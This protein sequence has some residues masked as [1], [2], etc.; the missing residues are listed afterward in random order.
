MIEPND[1]IL[2]G[3]LDG[4][5]VVAIVG[6]S[7]N[8]ARPSYQ[9]AQFWQGWGARIVPVNPGHAGELILGEQVWPDLAAIPAQTAVDTLDIFRRSEAVPDIVD[10]ALV[11]LP[12]LAVIWMQLGIRHPQAAV[13]ARARG[14]LV[15]EDRCPKI[16]AARLWFPGQPPTNYEV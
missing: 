3:A 11:H 2:R 6:L 9:V 1:N 5:H 13:R 15:I 16:E 4:A 10:Q 14:L 12:Q 7:P 8:P